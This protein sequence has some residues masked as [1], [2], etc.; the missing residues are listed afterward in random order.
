[1]AN[2]YCEGAVH[3]FIDLAESSPGGSTQY[4]GTCEQMPQPQLDWDYEGDMN[5]IGA[6]KRP[7]D[8]GYAGM[9]ALLALDMTRWSETVLR[10]LKSPPFY[11]ADG[12][13]D[14][15]TSRQARGS[16]SL[17]QGNTFTLWLVNDFWLSPQLGAPADLNPGLYFYA[18]RSIG[19]QQP[20]GGT[21]P[22][23]RRLEISAID[24][25][26]ANAV[27]ISGVAI[28]KGGFFCWTQNPAIFNRGL[29]NGLLY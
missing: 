7:L 26:F 24:A 18:C 4:L 13:A 16:F 10:I 12:L 19:Y 2:I 20:K 25:F 9:G 27:T 22:A 28:P 23:M 15:I 14:G 3:A 21:M 17:Q 29:F 5:D 1:M 8:E 6:R 11:G